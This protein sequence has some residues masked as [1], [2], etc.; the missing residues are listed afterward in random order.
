MVFT[1]GLVDYL[2]RRRCMLTG[3][4]MQCG[5]HIYMS[6]YM[7]TFRDSGNQAASNT[8]IASV[9]VYAIGWSKSHF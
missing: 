6:I 4:M 7:S 5:T 3:V 1:W 2:G 8:A 9:Y